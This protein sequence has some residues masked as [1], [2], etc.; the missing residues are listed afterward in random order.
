MI[1]LTSHIILFCFFPLSIFSGQESL[2]EH[3]FRAE[4]QQVKSATMAYKKRYGNYPLSEK[5][6]KDHTI[7]SIQELNKLIKI[8]AGNNPKKILFLQGYG[9]FYEFP[10]PKNFPIAITIDYNNDGKIK[11]GDEVLK[12]TVHTKLPPIPKHW[13]IPVWS[14]YLFI[15]LIIILILTIDHFRIK[16]AKAST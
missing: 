14:V 16:S 6:T 7:T 13:D 2:P 15:G 12:Q 9:Q 8:L 3:D 4:M 10:N 1:K 11:V 5:H